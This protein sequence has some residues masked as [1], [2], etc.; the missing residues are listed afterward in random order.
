MPVSSV[1]IV[2]AGP[3]GLMLSILLAIA[4]I[5]SIKILERASRPSDDTRAV[6]YQ[7]IAMREFQ[8][9]GIMDAVESA[10]F[11]PRKAMWRDMSGEALFE[12]PGTGM[13]ALT[14]DNLA[15][16]VQSELQKYAS[17]ELKWSHEVLALGEDHVKGV[18]WVD[19]QTLSGLQ[20]LEADYVVGCDGGDSTVRKLLL[21]PGSMA[22]F[23]WEKHLVAA[24]VRFQSPSGEAITD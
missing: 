7:P 16:I 12:L 4:G 1:I 5:P 24:D 18:A 3:A 19:V 15:A 17:A 10:G 6:F 22:G 9:A 23:T 13:I 11:R 8:R 20:R 2:G 14:Q 21:G